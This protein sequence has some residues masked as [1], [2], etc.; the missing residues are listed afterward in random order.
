[1]EP[2]YVGIGDATTFRGFCKKHEEIFERIDNGLFE[3]E[4]DLTVQLLRSIGWWRSMETERSQLIEDHQK[5]ILTHENEIYEKLGLT[6]MSEL[7]NVYDTG[8]SLTN[9]MYMDLASFV[10]NKKEELEQKLIAGRKVLKLGK[11]TILYCHLNFQIPL[12]LS[13]R[14]PFRLGE[15]IFCIHWTVVPHNAETEIVIFLDADGI[16][17]HLGEDCVEKNWSYRA[18]NDLAILETVEAAMAS[19]EFWYINPDTYEGLSDR[20]KENL[21]YDVRYKCMQSPVW[22]N[23][24]YTVFE[25]MWM[26]L[27]KKENDLKIINAA[28]EKMMLIPQEL[29]KDDWNIAEAKLS[30]EMFNIY[31]TGMHF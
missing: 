7:T 2:K 21:K 20:K 1:M 9:E 6:K 31:H 10:D 23:I 25:K 15:D 17:H 27:A 5:T 11:W 18:T 29:T 3:T 16:N 30:Y 26:E 24:D 14:H 28:K 12:A 19:S 8:I 4:Y 22:E 13:S